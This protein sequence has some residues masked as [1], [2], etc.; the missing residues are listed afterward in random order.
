MAKSLLVLGADTFQLGIIKFLKLKGFEVH[1]ISN[2]P[3]DLGNSIANFSH[4]VDYSKI[5]DVLNVF[6]LVEANQVFCSASDAALFYQIQIQ[7]KL[8]ISLQSPEYINFFLEKTNYKFRLSTIL[9]DHSPLLFKKDQLVDLINK[10]NWPINGVIAKTS[11]G[12]GSKNIII[13]KK[14]VQFLEF[15]SK[16]IEESYF[17][18]NFVDGEEIG[19]D[20]ICRNGQLLFY[21]PT[22][23]FVNSF[24]VP[25][26]HLVLK[27]NKN[28][29]PALDFL[30]KFIQLFEI[31]D[32]IYN[33]DLIVKNNNAYLI[34]ISPRIGGNCIPEVIE[35]SCGVNEYEWMFNFL[36]NG[37]LNFLKPNWQGQHGVY[38]FGSNKKGKLKKIV[39]DELPFQKQIVELY[40]K[41]KIGDE[42]EIFTEG[43]R[44]LGYVIFNANSDEELLKIYNEIEAFEWFLVD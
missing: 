11:K 34:D 21:K 44:H 29:K 17:F 8:G 26:A 28:E 23:K 32:G 41:F 4:N 18:E 12:S 31:K 33:V 19:G 10:K 25:I 7:K 3:N 6:N 20:F 9:E 36:M 24:C 40:W 27:E 13:F 37:N 35:K 15:A 1:V 5:N 43:S 39:K 16:K 38:I 30:K 2:R 14:P 22:M 42:V